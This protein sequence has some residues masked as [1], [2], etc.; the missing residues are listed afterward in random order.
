MKKSLILLLL[1]LLVSTTLWAHDFE[2][3]GIYYKKSTKDGILSASVDTI[4]WNIPSELLL[5][6]SQAREICMTLASGEKTGKKYYV[7][8]YVRKLH[9]KHAEGVAVYGNAQFYMEDVRGANST[10]DFMAYQVY[11]PNGKKITN[12][13]AVAVGDFVVVYGE[14]TN[15]YGTYETVGRGAAY[16]WKSSNPLL[17]S[18]NTDGDN[19]QD[20]DEN[21]S[22]DF[23]DDGTIENPYTANDV[24]LLDNS[25]GGYYWVK[26]YIVGQV[27][28]IS[29]SSSSEF[30][31]PF[32]SGTNA[33]GEPT[34][35]MANVLIADAADESDPDNCV[36]VQLP[37]GAVR[38][39]VNLVQ[40]PDNDGQEILLYGSL[41]RYFSVAGVKSTQFAKI[42]EKEFGINP[43]VVT[44]EP[45]N[46]PTAKVVTIAEFLAAPESAEV[47]Y[48]LTGVISGLSVGGYAV[49][50]GNFD[51]TDETGTVYVYGLTKDFIAVGSTK[52]DKSF[53]SLGLKDG[54][55]ITIRGFRGSYAGKIE[56]YGAYF[57]KLASG[58]KTTNP[59]GN[60]DNNGTDEPTPVD[61][62]V[63]DADVD[64]GNAS[65]DI[66]TATAY[67]ITKNGVTITVSNGIIGTYNNENHYRIYKNQTLTVTSTVGN[68]KKVSF[69]CTANDDVKYGPGCL[70]V[71]SGNY[72]Y[73]GFNG[74]WTGDDSTIVFT[75][76][77]NQVRAIQ[78]LVVVE[79]TSTTYAN[80]APSA[81]SI[82]NEDTTHYV[83]VTY[84]SLD[85]NNYSHITTIDIPE[86]VEHEGV[87]Y[88]VVGVGY[89]A[90]Y[91]NQT[92]DQI[93]IPQNI[94]SIG[95]AAFGSVVS[96]INFEA[97][98]PPTVT[99]Y[100]FARTSATIYVPCDCVGVY[101]S[102]FNKPIQE[103]SAVFN[104]QVSSTEN[105]SAEVLKNTLCGAQISA[106]PNFGYHFTQ[107]SD[108]NTDN[109][110]TL[111]LTQDTVLRADFTLSH[112]G[113]CG[114]SVYWDYD[115]TTQALAITGSGDM[116]DYT[117]DVQ[118]WTLFKENI[119]K[120]T[121][122]AQITTLGESA[123]EGC[124]RLGEVILGAGIE[125]IGANVFADCRRLYH[126]YSYP[127][128][129]PFAEQSSFANYNV[130]LH[131]PCESFEMY[132]LDVVF[133]NFKYIQCIS[134]DEVAADSVVINAGST[135]VT[136]IWP[137]D[138]D[139][140]TY[141]IV[142]YKNGEVV[143]TLTFNKDGQLLNIAFVPGRDGSH[144]AQYAEQTN[145]GYRFTVTGLEEGT[146][147]TY[148]V[149]SKD[150]AN[151]TISEHAG[152]F[153]TNSTT[154]LESTD[155]QNPTTDVRKEIRD[156][157]LIIISDGVEYNAQGVEL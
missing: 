157:Q 67:T 78:I 65:T 87:T 38:T 11:G 88:Q 112:E 17:S 22:T 39:G 103:H 19:N 31:A 131:V 120:I 121:T 46:E 73:S 148:T 14:L 50:Y 97:L 83:V 2:V 30:D 136:I 99:P 8:G 6:V 16:I 90:F 3:D 85:Q 34:G 89:N 59:D 79:D 133:G 98:T 132:N 32:T 27:S 77:S 152:A 102:V 156:G 146:G 68:I 18:S 48:E 45:T 118:P 25:R 49:I 107:W 139:A 134:S 106:T 94:N 42:G 74:Y 128:Y 71:N 63:F 66:N 81:Y 82:Q 126:V 143:C 13:D 100:T 24:L 80:K 123:F 142:I 76:S 91:N 151:K 4:G 53:A 115:L 29:V 138:P 149:T 37:S 122:S 96:T 72:N 21:L 113:Q 114:D 12:P 104:V 140:E 5:T 109:P 7:M 155:T 124:I 144:P 95:D 54:D 141:S 150:A 84:Q 129:T 93:T 101:Q 86:T 57:V 110:R 111:I 36:P 127:S 15:Y 69:T 1:A 108:G 28:S 52:N 117:N 10:Q 125:Y 56:V 130:Y 75:A 40:N 61:T 92:I 9:S 145:N 154:D 26:A 147:Y 116:Y 60:G 20:N 41:E 70:S 119:L 105:G 135:D 64:K 137:S 44:N 43:N 62:I 23:V 55:K 58:D 33:D 51:L 153:T 47:Y 35:Y